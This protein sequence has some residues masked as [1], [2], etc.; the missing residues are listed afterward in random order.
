MLRVV[1]PLVLLVA[2]DGLKEIFNT[3]DS[4]VEPFDDT[5]TEGDADTDSDADSDTDL[6]LRCD[7]EFSTDPPNGPDCLTTTV[8]CGDTVRGTTEGGSEQMDAELYQDAFC[9]IASND[10]YGPERVYALDVPEDTRVTLTVTT[11]C[12]DLSY[13][14][15]RWEETGRCPY[16]S[17]FSIQ[18]C[19]GRDRGAGGSSMIDVFNPARFLISIDG[20]AGVTAPFAFYVECSSF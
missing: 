17:S 18:E 14:M 10:Y 8:S 9:F 16:G 15:M 11:P 19:E 1:L 4:E 5:A 3:D 12:E 7:G 2:C 13:A 6:T 20:P